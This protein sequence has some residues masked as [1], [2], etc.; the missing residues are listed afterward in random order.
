MIR[1]QTRTH[2]KA[3]VAS[4]S[5]IASLG[6]AHAAI[7]TFVGS[8]DGAPTSGPFT[9]SA[10]AAAS[11]DLV[12]GTFGPLTTATF[13][14]LPVGY[15]SSFTAA[16]GLNVSLGVSDNGYSGVLDSNNGNLYGFN[17]TPGGSNWLGFSG[18]SATLSFAGGTHAVGFYLTGVQS[19]FTSTITL[20][21]ND[22]TTRTLN[23]PVN[24]D[25]GAAYYGFT[26][27]K[28]FSSVTISDISDD[29]WGIDDVTFSGAK[30]SAV[31]E[32]TSAALL[33]AG[34]AALTGCAVRRKR[35]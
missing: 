30:V 18:G 14:G 7:S 17:V 6:T 1:T 2:A 20:T 15:Q 23:A 11:F 28:S 4:L 34:L 19:I 13:E 26:D 33:I 22:G 16:P 27:S 25:G 10:T 32:P 21:F 12:A 29:A 5:L 31:P 35:G 24:D 8:D 3:L 9:D